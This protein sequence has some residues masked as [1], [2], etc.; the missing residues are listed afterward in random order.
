[1][2]WNDVRSATALDRLGSLA[3]GDQGQSLGQLIWFSPQLASQSMLPQM[4]RPR[5]SG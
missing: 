2:S 1:M 5:Q 4:Q 3:A